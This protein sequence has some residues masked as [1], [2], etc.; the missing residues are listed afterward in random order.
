MEFKIIHADLWLMNYS[1]CSHFPTDI[2]FLLYRYFQDKCSDELHTNFHQI[3]SLPLEPTMLI[4]E[5]IRPYFRTY[6]KSNKEI[7]SNSFFSRARKSHMFASLNTSPLHV[8][9]QSLYILLIHI[10]HLI[11]L[12]NFDCNSLPWVA[13]D[14]CT[15]LKPGNKVTCFVLE[16]SISP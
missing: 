6:S 1:L 13:I 2:A 15:K 16:K 5:S 8:K 12:R 3:K 14:P 4:P 11:Y 9:D 10:T 7:H